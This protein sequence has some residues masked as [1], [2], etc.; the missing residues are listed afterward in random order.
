MIMQI[1]SQKTNKFKNNNNKKKINV[2]W[3]CTS[4][5]WQAKK[6][7]LVFFSPAVASG[8]P[9]YENIFAIPVR[10]GKMAACVMFCFTL[11][12]SRHTSQ[13]GTVTAS[14]HI[15]RLRGNKTW[16]LADILF[17]W[18]FARVP[19]KYR[20]RYEYNI[21]KMDGTLFGRGLVKLNFSPV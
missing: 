12:N 17:D 21:W 11:T 5:T 7:T 6:A 4:L 16:F 8:T 1:S 20:P 15:K 13:Y 18:W 10:D 14:F 19:N 3:A 9:V 2:P